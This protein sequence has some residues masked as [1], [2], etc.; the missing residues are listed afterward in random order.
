MTCS[1]GSGS[2]SGLNVGNTCGDGS[3]VCVSDCYVYNGTCNTAP[4]G[5]Y[6]CSVD[7]TTTC[8]TLGA[9]C[10]VGSDTGTCVSSLVCDVDGS[11]DCAAQ[12]LGNAC[13]VG[14]STGTCKAKCTADTAVLCTANANCI[15]DYHGST[16]G[17]GCVTAA[18]NTTCTT[19]GVSCSQ[20]CN[21]DDCAY[22]VIRFVMGYDYPKNGAA[23]P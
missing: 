18:A 11:T 13:T 4:A 7:N 10:T 19:A 23:T 16:S 17:S 14:A 20:D 2:C 12:G 6:V 8:A 1:D 21:T 3:G 15:S 22:Q 9:S 5:T